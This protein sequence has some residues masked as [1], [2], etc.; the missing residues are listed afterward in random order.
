MLVGGDGDSHKR[1]DRGESN[2]PMSCYRVRLYETRMT[3]DDTD[4]VALFDIACEDDGRMW[5][6]PVFL[7]PLFRVL[8][9]GAL[10]SIESRQEMVGGLGAQAIAERLKQGLEPPFE[11]SIVLAADYPGAPGDPIPL[12]PYDHVTVCSERAEDDQVQ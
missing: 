11:V 9:M 5:R 12:S 8:H 2:G 7:S 1:D 4:D 3:T 10:P 6:V